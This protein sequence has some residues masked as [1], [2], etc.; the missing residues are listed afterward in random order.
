M[1]RTLEW[2]TALTS[3]GSSGG[4]LAAGSDTSGFVWWS[5]DSMRSRVTF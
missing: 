4:T 2:I 5:V 1:T 3:D